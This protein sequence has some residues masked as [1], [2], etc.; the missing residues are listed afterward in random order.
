MMV[1][2][3]AGRSFLTT[4]ALVLVAIAG[5][6]VTDMF[7]AKTD[8]A[9]SHIEATRLFD[10]GQALLKNGDPLKAV[11]KISDAIAIERDNRDYLRSL[12]AAELAAGESSDAQTTLASLLSRNSTD[13]LNNFLMAHVLVKEGRSADAVSYYHRAIYGSWKADAEGNRRRARLELIDL[14]AQ[15]NSKEELLAELLPMQDNAPQDLNARKRLGELFLLADSPTR[16]ADVFR[17][18]LHESP[19]NTDAYL[20]M[21]EAEFAQGNYRAAEKSFQTVLRLAPNDPKG[22]HWSDL[23]HELLQLDPTIRGLDS[24]ERWRRSL[25]LVQEVNNDVNSCLREDSSPELKEWATK[26]KAVLK[27]PANKPRVGDTFE[28][29]LD[30]AEQLWQIRQRE[31]QPQA[32]KDSAVALVLNRLAR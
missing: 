2:P 27:T 8:R 21:G 4:F 31:C 23:C 24:S 9:E 5:L 18:I 11:D 32:S 3:L 10:D 1:Q 14:L 15:Q 7:L 25:A 13:G 12:A 30:V 22:H 28:A 17:G 29:N 20:G 19:S 6:F 26:A 16:A